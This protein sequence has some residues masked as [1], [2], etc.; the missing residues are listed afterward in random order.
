MRSLV[1]GI[2]LAWV[3]ASDALAQAQLG[4]AP[5]AAVVGE[6]AYKE[7]TVAVVVESS[8]GLRAAAALRR[9][10]R[11]GGCVVVSLTEA[12]R[13]SPSEQPSALLLVRADNSR[14][15]VVYWDRHGRPD[16]LSATGRATQAQVDAVVLAFSSALIA[17]HRGTT[18]AVLFES[19]G[20]AGEP[21][22]RTEQQ[23]IFAMLGRATHAPRTNVYLHFEDF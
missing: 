12:Q 5:A 1:V 4:S 10:L 16:A 23:A 19:L 14:I 13:A 3:V 15:Q 17:R 22:K 11:E 18:P 8:G 7:P 6:S 9:S 20:R 21:G 2:V